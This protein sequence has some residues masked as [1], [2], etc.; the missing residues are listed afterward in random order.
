[1]TGFQPSL[2]LSGWLLLCNEQFTQLCLVNEAD[3]TK[4]TFQYFTGLIKH[5]QVLY[6][7]CEHLVAHR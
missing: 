6:L 2:A 4:Y 1:M 3:S 7:A 5:I